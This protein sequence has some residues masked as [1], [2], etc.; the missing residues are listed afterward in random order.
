MKIRD[1]GM[2]Q[3][4]IWQAFFDP[5][6]TLKQLGLTNKCVNLVEFGCGYGTFTIPCAQYISGMVYTFDIEPQMIIAAGKRASEAKVTNV[7]FAERDFIANGTGLADGLCD[8]AL[9]LNILHGE[10]PIALL[11]EAHRNLKQDGKVGVMHWNYDPSTPRG[12]KMYMRA[13]PQQ[14]VDWANEAE[15]TLSSAGIID[16]PPYHFGMVLE[17]LK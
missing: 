9:L 7:I 16:L 6:N 8:Y 13:K 11:T 10:N 2:P 4:E 15:L 1:S 3:E 5:L 17:K 12:P 14:I